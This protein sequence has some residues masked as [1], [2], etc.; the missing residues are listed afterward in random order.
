MLT[1]NDVTRLR[2]VNYPADTFLDRF[3][4][5]EVN[6]ALEGCESLDVLVEEEGSKGELRVPANIFGV[7]N[8]PSCLHGVDGRVVNVPPVSVVR[9]TNAKVIGFGAAIDEV[10]RLVGSRIVRGPEDAENVSTVNIRNYDG[11]ALLES[12]GRYRARHSGRPEPLNFRSTAF[13]LPF[14]EPGNYGSFIVRCLPK[15]LLLR[16]RLEEVGLS[17]ERVIRR[18]AYVVPD[19]TPWLRECL[20]LLGLPD[21]PIYSVREVCGDIFDALVVVTDFESEAFFGNRTVERLDRFCSSIGVKGDQSRK[22]L[23][24]SRL[25][26]VVARPW[27]RPLINEALIERRL[28][29]K[30]FEI[31][32]PETIS[33]SVQVQL[34]RS[35]SAAIGPSGSG[36]L[37]AA[38][39]TPGT[40]IVDIESFH[41]TVRQHAKLY[42]ST[43][44]NYSFLF[45]SMSADPNLSKHLWSWTVSDID[46]DAAVEFLEG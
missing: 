28:A 16:D 5:H 32:Y 24:S 3:P 22:K 8:D 19:R 42:S 30:G 36:M 40:R 45:G 31:V 10:G 17:S 23:Y 25:L 44:K 20:M 35:A 18:G 41:S 2:S 11:Y 14:I 6:V 38:F 33:L 26:N 37:N 1:V 9:L 43:A 4:I 15:L 21:M 13:F 29:E 12:E 46:L 39:C 34:F 7:P 27:Y